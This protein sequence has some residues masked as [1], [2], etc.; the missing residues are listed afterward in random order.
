[1]AAGRICRPENDP[2]SGAAPNDPVSSWTDTLPVSRVQAQCPG[3][4]QLRQMV[5]AGRDGRGD[6]GG[7]IT[8]LRV[9]C[10]T[11]SATI[12]GEA[13]LRLG[14]RSSWWTPAGRPFG[15]LE[16]VQVTDS[17]LRVRGWAID[18]DSVNPI[19]AW[20]DVDGKGGPTHAARARPD[21]A[22][23]YPDFGPNHGF[24]HEVPRVVGRHRVCAWGINVGP[25]GDS[26]L[27]C[28]TLDVPRDPSL[29]LPAGP[30]VGQLDSVSAAPGGLRA[31][32]WAIDPD[33]RDPI[34]VWLD[35]SGRGSPVLANGNRTDVGN[36]YP[37]YGPA[38]GFATVIQRPP[39]TY[40]VCAHGVNVGPGA[41][42]LLG[43]RSITVA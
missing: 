7:R 38:H 32:G 28:L 8:S 41:D 5:V 12:T 25:G 3:A 34:Y 19:Y 43:C 4:G 11:G 18:P 26:L 10:T 35:V 40:Q 13:A 36:V 24:Q 27:G 37:A 20:I 2:Y 14:M 16:R 33:S 29:T 23:V 6:F 30:P 39:G 22:A 42:R 17:S 31:N 21:V 9:D 15:N 1:M